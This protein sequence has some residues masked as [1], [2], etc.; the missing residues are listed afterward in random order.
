MVKYRTIVADPPWRYLNGDIPMGGVN[1]HF[2][3]MSNVEIAA[4]PVSG[5]AEKDAH[6]YLWATNPRL[7][8]ESHDAGVGPREIMSAWGF[9]CGAVASQ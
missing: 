4:L 2:P 7:F 8:A 9:D 1:K 5:L 6:L 3:T